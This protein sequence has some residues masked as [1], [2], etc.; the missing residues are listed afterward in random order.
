MSRPERPPLERGVSG[1]L[2]LL[3]GGEL[4]LLG[5]MPG[6]SNATFLA[7]LD[8]GGRTA[9]A[10]YKP[11][12]GETPL[13]DFPDGTLHRREAAA[14]VLAAALGWPNVP[15]TVVREGPHGPGA[16]QLFVDADYRHH[17]F[18]LRDERLADFAPVAAFDL[19]A[20]NA[21][22]K[23]G[24]L[25]LGADGLVYAIDHGVCF[26]VEPKLRTVIWEFAGEPMPGDLRA[27]VRRVAGEL[28]SGPLRE[29][30]LDLLDE[31]E[32]D[33]TA[34]RAERLA[35]VGRFPEPGPGRP[36]PWPPV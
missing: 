13:W 34:A 11:R 26:A 9:L 30:M 8:G 29:A 36:F 7:E 2:S 15:P 35:S 33:A 1:T 27:D 3:S 20:N 23:G 17:F 19:V 22:R 10:V 31:T 16:V 21:D 25:L 24:H 5:P 14:Y 18:T 28:R 32:V 12:D 4:R 6:A